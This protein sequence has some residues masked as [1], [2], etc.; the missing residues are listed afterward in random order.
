[1]GIMFDWKRCTLRFLTSYLYYCMSRLGTYQRERES[2]EFD[3][4]FIIERNLKYCQANKINPSNFLRYISHDES[5][6]FPV[7]LLQHL[8]FPSISFF[9]KNKI[10]KNSVGYMKRYIK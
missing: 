8:E 4:L 5:N 7:R 1:M 6:Q 9:M 3:C 2:L 10:K